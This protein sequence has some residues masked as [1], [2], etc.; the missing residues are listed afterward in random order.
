MRRNTSAPLVE[1]RIG[2]REYEHV[3]AEETAA[4][5]ARVGAAMGEKYWSDRVV[6]YVPHPLTMRLQP[7]AAAGAP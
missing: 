4:M 5:A 3:R 1:V 6:R 7:D 2:G